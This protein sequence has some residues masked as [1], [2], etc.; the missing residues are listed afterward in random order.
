MRKE[1]KE[2]SKDLKEGGIF[3]GERERSNISKINKI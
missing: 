1:L 3:N 2:T